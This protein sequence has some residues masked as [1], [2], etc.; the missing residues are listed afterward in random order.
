M[1]NDEMRGDARGK[2]IGFVV[3]MIVSIAIQ[4]WLL[5]KSRIGSNFAV[6]SI[7]AG[8]AGIY[9]TVL[10][11]RLLARSADTLEDR[12]GLPPASL[13]NSDR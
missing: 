9:A 5:P 3:L 13:V 1:G 10:I 12:P 7:L 6:L 2:G 11:A 8:G 4:S